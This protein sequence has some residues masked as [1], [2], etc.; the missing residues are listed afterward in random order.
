MMKNLLAPT[1]ASLEVLVGQVADE[2]A[3]RL[4]RGEQPEIE[5]YARRH[6]EAAGVLRQVLAALHQLRLPAAARSLDRVGDYRL[7]R[8]I[9]R[10]GM[11]VVYEAEQ[12]SLG[13]RVALKV[14]PLAAAL[15]ARQLQRFRNEAQAAAGLHHE[16][17]VPIFGV[18]CENG[19]HY[20][21]MQFIEGRSLADLIDGLRRTPEQKPGGGNTA[22]G[23]LTASYIPAPQAEAAEAI[24]PA[25]PDFFRSVARLGVHAA[26]ALEHAHQ[27]GVIHRD[28]KPGNLLLDNAGRLWVADF[29]LAHVQG[30]AG[31]TVT[32]DLVGTLRYM[33]PEQALAGRAPVDHR[34]DVYS[35]GA[36]LYEVLALR[37]PFG[38]R[39]RQ[40]LLGQIALEEPRPLRSLN[41]AVPPELA[42]VV[43]KALA[44]NAAERYASAQE[45]ADDLQRFL[46]DRPIRARPPGWA[47]RAGRW[48]RRHRP[49]VAAALAS[50]LVVLVLAVVLLAFGIQKIRGEQKQTEEALHREEQARADATRALEREQQ[51]AYLQRVALAEREL[52]ANNVGRA[53]ELLAECPERLRGW[54]WHYLK[55]LPRTGPRV[56]RASDGWATA[57]AVSSDGKLLASAGINR[58]FFSEIR[59]WDAETGKAL[60]VLRGP[61]GPTAALAF[62]PDGK[63]LASAGMDPGIRLWDV[64]SGQALRTLRG[65]T[66]VVVGVAFNPDGRH[67]ASASLDGT[68]QVWRPGTG[69]EVL[70]YRGHS[71]PVLCL[72]YSPDGKRLASCGA[73]S[74]IRI[75]EA[76]AG[77]EGLRLPGHLGRVFSIAFSPDGMALASSGADGLRLWSTATG[78]QTLELLGIHNTALRVVWAADGR[79]F[80]ANW[81]KTVRLWDV[82]SPQGARQTGQ[83]VLT[84]HG[85]TDVVMGLA[86]NPASG[87]LVSSSMDGTVRIWDGSALETPLPGRRIL[88][89]HSGHVLGL[90]FSPDNR[91]LATASFD[92][93]VRTWDTSTGKEQHTLR[94]HDTIVTSVAFREDKQVASVS[95]DG[96]VILWDAKGGKIVRVFR[97]QLG[98]VLSVGFNVPF[99]PGGERFASLGWDLSLKVWDTATGKQEWSI[100]HGLPPL[101]STAYSPDGKQIAAATLGAMLL[102]DART[103]KQVDSFPGIAH[104]VHSLAFSADGK[105]LAAAS[106]DGTARVWEVKTGKEL[107]VFRHADRVLGVAF[108]PDGRYLAS[109]SCDNTAKVWDL[110]T[111]KE[112]TTLRGHI[113]YVMAV[114][115]SPDGKLLATAGGNRYEGEVQLWDTAAWVGNDRGPPGR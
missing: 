55:R 96:T 81:D 42:T 99:G 104:I 108:S 34:T 11:G 17:I 75:W 16:H 32:G 60:L 111:G 58:F 20:Y 13:R 57:V 12:L 51:T 30:A 102:Y 94:G 62:S 31:L 35:L 28:V 8:E 74:V 40:E 47:Q 37:P 80:S 63:Q 105:R 27:Q 39:D 107:H 78:K 54:E 106:W 4:D 22:A 85:H 115:F 56:L 65:H 88:T 109:G 1:E 95:L 67:L 46:D 113:G 84:L 64:T 98:Q 24:R 86:Y 2:F 59:L 68:V 43:H 7:V 10:G 15:D 36:T 72:A 48:A 49:A 3:L 79:L 91:R 38:G 87:R 66:G 71:G 25:A 103:G 112:V 77:E 14:L 82:S 89:G 6:P 100:A 41:R 92:G 61:F 53:E 70:R 114:S 21:A 52:A 29:G 19:V 18:G 90:A 5:E 9:G 45:L 76:R 73:D 33:S 101:M 44:K 110:E 93:T 83:E 26:L 69:E 23:D 50:S 97:G